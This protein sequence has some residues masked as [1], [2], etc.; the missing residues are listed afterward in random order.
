MQNRSWSTRLLTLGLVLLSAFAVLGLA[1]TIRPKIPPPEF[2]R[3]FDVDAAGLRQ[4]KAFDVTCDHCKGVKSQ[5]CENCKETKYP[6]CIECNGEK[7][8][9]CRPCGGKG[10]LPDPLVEL[11]CPYCHGSSWHT[12]GL[13]NGF[14]YLS[15]DNVQ[16]KCDT[17]KQKGL[18]ACGVCNKAR[19]LEVIKVGKKSVG[20][21]SSKDLKPL[22]E[23]LQATQAALEKF[24]PDTNVSKANKAFEELF[25]PI[26]KEKVVKDLVKMV[27]EHTKS[28]NNGGGGFS[29]NEE[30]LKTQFFLFK[31]RTTFLL[32][33]EIRA[34]EQALERAVHNESK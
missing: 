33:H 10:K 3:E 11:A 20:E 5:V 8:A 21:A 25:K 13:C 14:G 7:H 1:Q 6:T 9:T 30:R 19:R 28:V 2:K 32:Q 15:I 27:E 34:V 31:D 16:T 22:L 24:E 18:I 4:W 29:G 23:K 26:G 12:C 17:C